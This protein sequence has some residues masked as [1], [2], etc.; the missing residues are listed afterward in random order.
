MLYIK[1]PTERTDEVLKS[2]STWGR[3][4]PSNT[5]PQLWILLQNT[6]RREQL[7]F[8]QKSYFTGPYKNYSKT[9]HS[10][11]NS[12]YV[13][14]THYCG[15]EFESI[16]TKWEQVHC[17]RILLGRKC[18][19]FPLAGL[20]F[21][22]TPYRENNISPL[23]YNS[24]HINIRKLNLSQLHLN[25]YFPWGC[26]FLFQTNKI[27]IYLKGFVS[28]KPRSYFFNFSGFINQ[29]LLLFLV[30]CF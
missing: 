30:G 21:P 15:L 22:P 6:L 3:P 11:I 25:F 16:I 8:C 9:N 29:K 19:Q 28:F 24:Q 27:Q 1:I 13:V 12:T 26:R 14:V 17:N 23:C 18:S 20:S 2:S 5:Q 7:Y 4:K 10:S